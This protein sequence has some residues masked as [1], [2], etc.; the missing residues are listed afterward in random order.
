MCVF[1]DR[2][3]Q[4][5]TESGFMESRESNL[6]ALV[7]KAKVYPLHHGGFFKWQIGMFKLTP[8]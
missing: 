5:L 4:R 6:R 1:Y 3:T 8:L 7:Y 2:S